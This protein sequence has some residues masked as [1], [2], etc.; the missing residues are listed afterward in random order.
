MIVLSGPNEFC[1]RCFKLLEKDEKAF[2][3]QHE[4]HYLFCLNCFREA[5]EM[6]EFSCKTCGGKFSNQAFLIEHWNLQHKDKNCS[7]CLKLK[8]KPSH[9]IFCP[10]C[11]QAL[12]KNPITETQLSRLDRQILRSARRMQRWENRLGN[13]L[14]LRST[15]L[16]KHN[17]F[18]NGQ[19]VNLFCGHGNR[20]GQCIPCNPIFEKMTEES[21]KHG[22]KSFLARVSNENKPKKEKPKVE[23]IEVD[24]D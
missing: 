1:W 23:I 5:V 12:A 19:E 22:M 15:I 4:T 24:L 18:I 3:P 6:L 7:R 10:D 13:L 8:P 20:K 14:A 16:E 17:G 9:N 2:Q 21:A 11:E